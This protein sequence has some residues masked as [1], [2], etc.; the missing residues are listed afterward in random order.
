MVQEV[1]VW[2]TVTLAVLYL[3]RKLLGRGPAPPPRPSNAPDV[4]VSALV[5]KK[6]SPPREHAGCDH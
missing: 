4:P 3:G 5:R 2:V 6:G 1:L